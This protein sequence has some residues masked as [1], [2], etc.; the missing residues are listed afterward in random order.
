MRNLHV[1]GYCF[2]GLP[3]VRLLIFNQ[4][5]LLVYHQLPFGQGVRS[6]VAAGVLFASAFVTTARSHKASFKA[7]L[8]P[9]PPHLRSGS[10][11]DQ[12]CVG[13]AV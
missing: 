7:T 10:F 13:C 9:S 5:R 3:Q 2:L 8:K 4:S 1:L 11:D 6:I 12:V